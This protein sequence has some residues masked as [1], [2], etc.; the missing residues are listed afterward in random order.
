MAVIL[1]FKWLLGNM[2]KSALQNKV[3]RFS[4]GGQSDSWENISVLILHISNRGDR[5]VAKRGLRPE[6]RDSKD[7]AGRPNW[8]QHQQGE[9]C[10]KHQLQFSQWYQVNNTLFSNYAITDFD[11]NLFQPWK[12]LLATVSWVQHRL[13]MTI[14]KD[15]KGRLGNTLICIAID[16]QSISIDNTSDWIFNNHTAFWEM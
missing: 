8:V 1:T 16:M 11:F 14:I 7:L 2:E 6:R 9:A 5:R 13:S 12:M 3:N 10:L 4:V 15:A